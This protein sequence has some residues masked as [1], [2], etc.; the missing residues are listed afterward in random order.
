LPNQTANWCETLNP[1]RFPDYEGCFTTVHS[2]QQGLDLD[3]DHYAWRMYVIEAES[4]DG[5]GNIETHEPTVSYGRWEWVENTPTGDRYRV[6]AM[7]WDFVE[8]EDDHL[9]VT[10]QTLV[11]DLFLQ[12]QPI[13]DTDADTDGDTDTDS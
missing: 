12:P 3:A 4:C 7:S 9:Q 13:P 1:T 11:F 5:S 2:C 6:I 8:I 10:H